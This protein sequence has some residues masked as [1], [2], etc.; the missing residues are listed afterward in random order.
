MAAF[1]ARPERR[2]VTREQAEKVAG[3]VVPQA[4]DAAKVVLPD[5]A[6]LTPATPMPAAQRLSVI[7]LR[8]ARKA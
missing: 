4:K 3:T 6:P 7:W 2:D 8:E 5:H 1:R